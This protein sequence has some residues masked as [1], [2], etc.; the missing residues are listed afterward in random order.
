M[1]ACTLCGASPICSILLTQ[2]HQRGCIHTEQAW[3]S[4]AAAEGLLSPH[5]T[6][7]VYPKP[8]VL[9]STTV[10]RRAEVWTHPVYALAFP[11]AFLDSYSRE[12]LLWDTKFHCS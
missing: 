11:A 5:Q 1:G 10:A 8:A 7:R 3:E 4:C 6:A 2:Q 9:K 12:H